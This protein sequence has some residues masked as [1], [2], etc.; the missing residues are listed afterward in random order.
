MAGGTRGWRQVSAQDARGPR[1]ARKEQEACVSRCWLLELEKPHAR[2]EYVCPMGPHA[3]H[4][5]CCLDAAKRAVSGWVS[6][7][8]GSRERGREKIPRGAIDRRG[9]MRGIVD[10]SGVTGPRSGSVGNTHISTGSSLAPEGGRR[11]VLGVTDRGTSVC[12]RRAASER[13][14]PAA[15]R[16]RRS[17]RRHSGNRMLAVAPW[18]VRRIRGYMQ[19]RTPE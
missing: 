17:R 13:E 5:A 10:G 18:I 12:P 8:K 2:T 15:G 19:S 3:A 4:V 11:N 1:G 14:K 6:R 9:G 7:E 16:S